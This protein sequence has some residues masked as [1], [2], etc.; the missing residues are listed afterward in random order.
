METGVA[1][2][3]A[4]TFANVSATAVTGGGDL[5]PFYGAKFT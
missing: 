1:E 3:E 4:V 2:R 5:F